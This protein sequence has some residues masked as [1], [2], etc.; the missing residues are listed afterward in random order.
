[1]LRTI[2]YFLAFGLLSLCACKKDQ[3]KTN[4][5]VAAIKY[6]L[7]SKLT[8]TTS[9]KTYVEAYTY[10]T[11]HFYKNNPIELR[12]EIAGKIVKFFYTTS[13]WGTSLAETDEYDITSNQLI[14][15]YHFNGYA[16]SA[17]TSGPY[18]MDVSVTNEGSGTVVRSLGFTK[19]TLNGPVDLIT[20]GPNT[21]DAYYDNSNNITGFNSGNWNGGAESITY[22]YDSNNNPLSLL[23][24]ANDYL[25]FFAY[26]MP[27]T[28]VNNPLSISVGGVSKTYSYQYNQYGYPTSALVSDGSKIKY[29]YIAKK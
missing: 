21:T 7:L 23:A 25:T 4:Q 5:T 2:K 12:S 13:Q 22:T 20:N 15:V 29:D 14:D 26:A 19:T 1:M 18:Q 27:Q 17:P 11:N 24:T 6:P 8:V 9:T 3:P 10:D 16:A 28:F